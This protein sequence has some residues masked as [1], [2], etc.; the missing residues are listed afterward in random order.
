MTARN[1]ITGDS[2]KSKSN[3]DNYR[4]R[5]DAIDWSVKM[6][7]PKEETKTEEKPTDGDKNK[8]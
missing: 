2:I 4:N 1:D 3:S 7:K 8:D 5:F 6:E